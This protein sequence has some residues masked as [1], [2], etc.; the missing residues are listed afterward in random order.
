MAPLPRDIITPRLVDYV[1]RS[2]AYEGRLRYPEIDR[3]IDLLGYRTPHGEMDPPPQKLGRA[4]QVDISFAY[5]C[6]GI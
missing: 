3:N 5:G 1:V 6:D 4:S 2:F